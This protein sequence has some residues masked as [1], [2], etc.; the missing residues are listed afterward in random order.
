M[1]GDVVGRE[2]KQ[3]YVYPSNVRTRSMLCSVQEDY[4]LCEADF[5]RLKNGKSSCSDFAINTLISG[6]GAVIL[7]GAKLFMKI[8]DGQDIKIEKYEI[9]VVLMIAAVSL[10]LFLIGQIL[11]SEKSRVLKDME[12]HF[13]KATRTREVRG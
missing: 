1:P 4:A 12:R 5:V 2:L 6:V 8:V 3:P 13:C 11:P 7:V 10:V 9:Y